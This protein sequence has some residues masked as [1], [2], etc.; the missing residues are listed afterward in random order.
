MPSI[1]P[2]IYSRLETVLLKCGPFSNNDSLRA[3]FIDSRI[4]AWRTDL[5][6]TNNRTERVRLTIEYLCQQ[7]NDKGENALLLLLQVI[8]EHTSVGDACHQELI[9]LSDE[10][11]ISLDED[12]I[13]E[14][15]NRKKFSLRRFLEN[16]L[17]HKRE[18]YGDVIAQEM[19]VSG[20]AENIFQ[21]GKMSGNGTLKI[22]K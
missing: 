20:Q 9:Q 21:I 3:I 22:K 16:L 13:S 19:D 6:E 8:S 15:Q 12:S 2:N 10:L 14:P 18:S 1:T 5:Y 17:S 4:S 7:Y 11:R